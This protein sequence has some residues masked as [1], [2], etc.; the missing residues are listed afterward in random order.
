MRKRDR[1]FYIIVGLL[2]GIYVYFWILNKVDQMGVIGGDWSTI[3]SSIISYSPYLIGLGLGF[4]F[5]IRDRGNRNTTPIRITLLTGVIGV[6]LSGLF[7]ELN[8]DGI[9][10][11]DIISASYTITDFQFTLVVVFLILGMIMGLSKK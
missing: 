8:T 1:R 11:N 3:T 5:L 4:A 7:Y 6:C 9:W 10:V 2:F